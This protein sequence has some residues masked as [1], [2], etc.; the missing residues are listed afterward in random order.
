MMIRARLSG[1]SVSRT[2]NLIGTIMSMVIK[3]YTNLG[4]MSSTK[5]QRANVEVEGSCY[6][7][8][9]ISFARKRKTTLQQ[10]TRVRGISPFKTPKP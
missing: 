5:Q 8:V 6:A 4:K 10:I 1:A 3:A 2:T 9:E 7:G